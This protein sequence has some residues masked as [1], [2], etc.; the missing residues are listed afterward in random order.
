MRKKL[1]VFAVVLI[2][3]I[4]VPLVIAQIA[5]ETQNIHVTGTANYPNLPPGVTPAPSS[6]PDPTSS[7]TVK[8]SLFFLNGTAFPT[9]ISGNSLYVFVVDPSHGGSQFAGVNP[10]EIMVRNDGTVPINVTANAFNVNLPSDMS[11]TFLAGDSGMHSPL[12]VGVGQ[13]STLY[14][15]IEMLPT[16][17]SYTPHQTFSYSFDMSITATQT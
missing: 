11:L 16:A 12:T 10:N 13:S 4:A 9:T 5:Q 6:T 2:L 17:Y 3:V 7:P 8:F 15:V 14:I 1:L